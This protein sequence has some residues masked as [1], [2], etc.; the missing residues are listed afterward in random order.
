MISSVSSILP[1]TPRPLH[2]HNQAA[3]GPNQS[4]IHLFGSYHNGRN[5]VGLYT[6][7][8]QKKINKMH[9]NPMDGCT[10]FFSKGVDRLF[11]GVSTGALRPREQLFPNAS[12]TRLALF[13]TSWMDGDA[14]G[15]ASPWPRHHAPCVVLHGFGTTSGSFALCFLPCG[16]AREM[17]CVKKGPV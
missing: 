5:L 11:S 6:H 3:I 17:R 2:H 1:A 13:Q 10:S 8:P 16:G 12:A 7:T 9:C 4:P 14:D 15:W